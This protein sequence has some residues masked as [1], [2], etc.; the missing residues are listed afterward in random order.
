TL[1][2]GISEQM[3][4]TRLR[5]D[6]AHDA[7]ANDLVLQ[8]SADQATLANVH[9]ATKELNEPQCPIYQ[10]CTYVGMGTRTQAENAMSNQGGG[11]F[12]CS[13]RHH[14]RSIPIAAGTVLGTLAIIV[15]GARRRRRVTVD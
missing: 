15:L 4:V 2:A 1:F 10:G 5:A 11:L 6:L 3:R 14:A 13:I 12:S 7:L 8:A 9:Q